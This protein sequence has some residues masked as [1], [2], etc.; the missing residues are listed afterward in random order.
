MNDLWSRLDFGFFEPVWLGVG[1][2]AVFAVFLL[3]LGAARRRKQAVRL[4]AAEHLLPGLTGSVSPSRR[5]LKRALLLVSVALVF[6]ALARPHLLFQWTEE[7]RRGLDVLLAVD[8]SKSMLS[9]DVKPS[10]L[11]RAKLA[12]EDFADRLPD[13]RLGLI[14]FAGD[15]FLECPL[16]LDHGA[17]LDAVRELD[18]DTIPRPGT[19]IA[20]AI[21]NAVDALKSQPNNVKFLILI[22]DG[23]DLEGRVLDA[24]QTAAQSGLKIYT[25]GVGT[26]AG[27]LIPEQDE[28]GATSFHHDSD[29]ELVHSRLDEATLRSIARI[30]GGAYEPLG[31]RGEGL[32]KIYDRYIAT[33]PRQ[34]LEERREKIR[35]E[36]YEWPLGLAILLL[37]W[38]FLIRERAAL[39]VAPTPAAPGTGR[40]IRRRSTPAAPVALLFLAL[41]GASGFATARAAS[42]DVAERDYKAGHYADAEQKYGEALDHQPDRPDLQYDRGDAAYRAGE[43]NEA[44]EAFRKALETPNLNLQEN[45]YYNLGNTQFKHGEAMEKVDNSRARQLWEQ[46]LGSYTS[47]LKLKDA[48]DTRHNYDV[49]KRKLEDLKRRQQ[50]QQSQNNPSSGNQQN[51]SQ[52]SSSGGQG[53]DGNQGDQSQNSQGQNN[54]QNGPPKTGQDPG[55]Q[56]QAGNQNQPGQ[57]GPE[58]SAQAQSGA[59]KNGTAQQRARTM[60]SR[61]QDKQDPGIKSRQEAEAL[62]DSLKDDEHHVSARS[63]TGNNQPPP[64]ASGKDW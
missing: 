45:S 56:Q 39:T 12:V 42:S 50:Q 1:L 13:N 4:F 35:F 37:A 2:L 44:E 19:D 9:D 48:A 22:T 5:L 21:D 58:K 26:P 11:E 55:Q 28:T 17:F 34:N 8:C 49:V 57:S 51:Q 6:L 64:T 43:Y 27:S 33:L 38:E 31:Q 61:E 40:R 59:D 20:T 36:R 18:T 10:R 30:T 46:A 14:A 47:A 41:L 32:Q 52:Q 15:S 54:P 63:L 24:A 3:E 23:E 53:Q 29:G 16:T 7:S 62:L 25:V 60:G